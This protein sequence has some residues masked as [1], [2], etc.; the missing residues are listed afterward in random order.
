MTPRLQVPDTACHV[1]ARYS[2]PCSQYVPGAICKSLNHSFIYDTYHILASAKSE[3]R[4]SGD[5]IVRD[6]RETRHPGAGTANVDAGTG[7][8][9]IAQIA[10]AARAR[11]LDIYAIGL[12][13][14]SGSSNRS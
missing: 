7:G 13:V 10:T 6:A 9:L 1:Y 12:V 8:S 3:S 2:A 14:A 4:I 11:E 5:Q